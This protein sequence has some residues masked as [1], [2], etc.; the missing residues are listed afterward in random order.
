[1]PPIFKALASIMA[2]VL[3]VSSLFLVATSLLF[4]TLGG[5]LFVVGRTPPIFYVLTWA[6]A[7]GMGILSVCVMRLRQKME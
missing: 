1:M 5:D 4:G 6:L 2:W 7:T 3:F